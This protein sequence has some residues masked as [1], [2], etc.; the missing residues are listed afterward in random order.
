MRVSSNRTNLTSRALRILAVFAACFAVTGAVAF[1]ASQSQLNSLNQKIG[2]KQSQLGKTKGREKVLVSEVAKYTDKINGLQGKINP[3]QSRWNVLQA[4]FQKSKTVL[5]Q[6]QSELR[7]E[8]ARLTKLKKRL[9]VS[10]T[11]LAARLRELYVVQKPS[12]ISVVL[13]AKGFS[14]LLERGEFLSRIG[15]QDKRIITTVSDAK[16]DSQATEKKLATLEAKQS[17]VTEKIQA[18]KT[19]VEDVKLKLESA[20]DDVAA[21]R[22]E[23]GKVL[24]NVRATRKEQEEDLAEMQ[25]QQSNIQAKLA[26]VDPGTIKKGSGSL[27]WP[28]SAGQVTSPFGMRWGRLHA[29]I[30][31]AIPVG[32]PLHAVDD[33]TVAISGSVGG[34]GLYICINHGNNFSS[35]YGHNSSLKVSVGQHVSKGQ[36]IS[37]S[38]NTGNSTGPHLHFETRVGGT[39]QNPMNYL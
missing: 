39:P 11:K 38:G 29:G 22:R 15:A 35:C 26:G 7:Q 37:L 5:N 13:N 14:D 36:I 31:I 8:T 17:E 24:S 33:G 6:T 1:A 12:L 25:K 9:D 2:S 34:Y 30:D 28:T 4:D 27:I 19:E 10:E 20:R 18:R 23:R 16:K 21:V 32:T 3:L